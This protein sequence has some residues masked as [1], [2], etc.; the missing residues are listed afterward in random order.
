MRLRPPF[1]ALAAMLALAPHAAMAQD[2]GISQRKQER[3]LAKKE[4]EEKKAKAKEEKA[5]RK[6]HLSLQD[7]ATRKRI[8]Q[9]TRRADRHGSG[10]HRDDFPARLFRRKR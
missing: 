6:H 4:R 5:D 1:W 3:N 8:K 7:K 10:R 9:H 2:E